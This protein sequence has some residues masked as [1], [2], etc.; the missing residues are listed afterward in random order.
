MLW[1]R[2]EPRR[3]SYGHH[4]STTNLHSN[5]NLHTCV[6]HTC[7][8]ARTHTHARTHARTRAHKHTHA[9]MDARTHAHLNEQVAYKRGVAGPKQMA[10]GSNYCQHGCLV[11]LE[12]W[13]TLTRALSHRKVFYKKSDYKQKEVYCDILRFENTKWRSDCVLFVCAIVYKKNGVQ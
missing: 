2:P 12:T 4:H 9:R 6:W 1:Y 10:P 5:T 8:R 11:K 13:W 7:A 3:A